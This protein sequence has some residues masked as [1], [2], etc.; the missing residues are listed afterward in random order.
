[1]NDALAKLAAKDAVIDVITALFIATDDR[2]W[3]AV[4]ECFAPRVLFD[5][6][7]LSGEAA[8]EVDADTIVEGWRRGLERLTAVHH[9]AGNFRVTICD[10]EATAFCYGIALHYWKEA[11]GRTTRTFVGSYDFHL[12]PHEQSWVI[13]RFKFNVKIVAGNPDLDQG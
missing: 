11:G 6:S 7:S 4:R 1:L 13:D 8:A 2:N 12:R 3:P 10:G 5:M 9:Q